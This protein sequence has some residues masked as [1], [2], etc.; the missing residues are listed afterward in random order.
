MWNWENCVYP[1]NRNYG[2]L[3]NNE[4]NDYFWRNIASLTFPWETLGIWN[5]WIKIMKVKFSDIYPFTI[6]IKTFTWL[7][8]F[9]DDQWSFQI[10]LNVSLLEHVY[11]YNYERF[12]PVEWSSVRIFKRSLFCPSFQNTHVNFS[13]LDTFFAML[14]SF[15]L[16][17]L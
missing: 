9:K 1:P 12:F 4:M 5:Y 14:F 8:T 11:R 2:F 15:I 16:P 10:M 17:G 6:N 7:F 3:P 13:F